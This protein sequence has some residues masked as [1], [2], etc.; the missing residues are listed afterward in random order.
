MYVC[1]FICPRSIHIEIMNVNIVKFAW[2]VDA[3]LDP[4][5]F[6]LTSLSNDI[7]IP[8]GQHRFAISNPLLNLH[9]NTTKEKGIAGEILI[10]MTV[11][12]LRTEK[13][14]IR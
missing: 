11:S 3:T 2:I 12:P 7:S 10:K 14:F 5:V 6:Y 9:V 13:N 8:E 1:N 4:S